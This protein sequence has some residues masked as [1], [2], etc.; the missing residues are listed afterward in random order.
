MLDLSKLEINVVDPMVIDAIDGAVREFDNT[1]LLDYMEWQII[2]T[3]VPFLDDRFRNAT[4]VH[5]FFKN[6]HTFSNS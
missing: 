4:Q 6:Y 3:T 2:L 1:T 5:T